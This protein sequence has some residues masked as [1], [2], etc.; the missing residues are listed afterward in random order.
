VPQE[1]HGLVGE[2]RQRD[3]QDRRCRERGVLP[4]GG[5]GPRELVAQ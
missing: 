5:V 4:R 1:Q 2:R 3:A